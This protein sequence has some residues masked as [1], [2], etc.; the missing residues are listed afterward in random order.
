MGKLR[1]RSQVIFPK[2]TE[3][4]SQNLI[5]GFVSSSSSPLYCILLCIFIFLFILLPTT[6][7]L[8]SHTSKRSHLCAYCCAKS[9]KVKKIIY[10]PHF[11]FSHICVWE[12]AHYCLSQGHD[13]FLTL[14]LLFFFLMWKTWLHVEM[15]SNTQRRKRLT[16]FYDI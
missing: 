13:I 5:L 11:F 3:K 12:T 14:F 1:L 6:L 8:E 10:V 4:Y 9:Y 7:M 16:I 15:D 2:V